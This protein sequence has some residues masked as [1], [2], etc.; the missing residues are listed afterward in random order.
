M[1]NR[2]LAQDALNKFNI[3][4]SSDG[5]VVAEAGTGSRYEIYKVQSVQ[6][7]E[8][9]IVVRFPR[10]AVFGITPGMYVTPSYL[11]GKTELRHPGDIYA[12][13]KCLEA[14]V[15]ISFPEP[16]RWWE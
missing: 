11:A 6:D 12:V 4:E 13:L 9:I 7:G 8:T 1:S 14:L 3:I 5:G 16:G 15:D 2:A 10:S